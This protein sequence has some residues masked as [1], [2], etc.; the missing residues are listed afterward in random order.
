MATS[1]DDMK[2]FIDEKFG[3]L[4][5]KIYKIIEEPDLSSKEEN[6]TPLT[7]KEFVCF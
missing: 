1:V 7:I 4:D 3:E 2:K 6:L 5:R